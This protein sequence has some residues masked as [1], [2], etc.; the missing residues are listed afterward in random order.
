M[1]D[2]AVALD[3]HTKKNVTKLECVYKNAADHFL[4]RLCILYV[5]PVGVV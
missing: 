3:P 4:R 5:L 1:E 2:D